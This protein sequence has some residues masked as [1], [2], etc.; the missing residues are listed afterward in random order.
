MDIVT[1]RAVPLVRSLG[2]FLRG[3]AI[4]KGDGQKQRRGLAFL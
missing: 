2:C 4:G 3:P 1:D